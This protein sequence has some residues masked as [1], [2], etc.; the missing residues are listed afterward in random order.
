M[1]YSLTDIQKR[2]LSAA[3]EARYS[4]AIA[5]HPMRDGRVLVKAGNETFETG[6]VE[7]P[8]LGLASLGLLRPIPG[9]FFE[10][11][12]EGRRIAASLGATTQ[13]TGTT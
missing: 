6:P 3:S 10:L 2:I 4:P 9:G 11:T 1:D 12:E 5:R 8:V 13:G 7:R